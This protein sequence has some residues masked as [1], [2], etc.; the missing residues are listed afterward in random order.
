MGRKADRECAY[1]DSQD[2]FLPQGRPAWGRIV[3]GAS[4]HIPVVHV[5]FFFLFGSQN[6]ALIVN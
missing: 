4:G 1:H 3:S 2:Y 6:R 5:I